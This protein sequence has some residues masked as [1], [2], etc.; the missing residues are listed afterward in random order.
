[1]EMDVGKFKK[2]TNSLDFKSGTA[3]NGHWLYK[4]TLK[5]YIIVR[6]KT[7]F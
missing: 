1:M 3:S 7:I 6:N 5:E 4:T 2:N